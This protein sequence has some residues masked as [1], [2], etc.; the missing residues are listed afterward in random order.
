MSSLLDGT[1]PK[2]VEKARQLCS[3]IAQML[4]VRHRARFASSPA[5]AVLDSI[6]EHPSGCSDAIRDCSSLH[7]F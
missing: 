7:V 1:F 2:D 3:R 4:N 5:A 6:F